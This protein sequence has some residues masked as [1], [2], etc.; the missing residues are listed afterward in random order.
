MVLQSEFVEPLNDMLHNFLALFSVSLCPFGKTEFELSADAFRRFGK[1]R[2]PARLNFGDCMA[3]A[4]SQSTGEPL[5][6][7][8]SDFSKTDVR[9]HRAS[10]TA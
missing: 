9:V 8:G 10:S 7:K 5:L 3:Y 4:T 1:G 2:H 6:F